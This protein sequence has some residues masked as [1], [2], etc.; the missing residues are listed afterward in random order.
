MRESDSEIGRR[1]QWWVWGT[2]YNLR[3]G[4]QG[5]WDFE[6]GLGRGQWG[7]G[8]GAEGR[9]MPHS[10]PEIHG[11]RENKQTPLGSLQ[12]TTWFQISRPGRWRGWGFWEL[13]DTREE[14]PESQGE[15]WVGR[16]MRSNQSLHRA[17]WD[18]S[19]GDGWMSERLGYDCHLP[20][21]KLCRMLLRHG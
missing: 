7:R 17:V 15:G 8:S 10:R 9:P 18:K 16:G 3:Q 13:A 4:L 14:F 12:E 20:Q 11:V 5:S 19:S 1:Q 6:G 21:P 2:E